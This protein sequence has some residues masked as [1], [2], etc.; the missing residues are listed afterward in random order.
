MTLIVLVMMTSFSESGSEVW[1]L[2][3]EGRNEDGSEED[4]CIED[5][6]IVNQTDKSS[7]QPSVVT[8]NS[9][10]IEPLHKHKVQSK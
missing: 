7:G 10:P 1:D 9:N 4:D 6:E 3:S 5:V 8:P 2:D